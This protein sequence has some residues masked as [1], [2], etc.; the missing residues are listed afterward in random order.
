MTG[1]T[2]SIRGKTDI[3]GR[4]I[5]YRL[6][7]THETI[8]DAV[9]EMTVGDMDVSGRVRWK[10]FKSYD[11]W[12]TDSLNRRDDKLVLAIPKQPAAGKVIYDVSLTGPDGIERKLTDESVIIRFKGVVPPY[13]LWPHVVFMFIGMLVSNR[14]GLEAV[15]GG[16]GVFSYGL[17]TTILMV[18][19]G[20]IFGPIVQKYAFGAFWTGWP[21][22]HDLTDNK[23]FVAIIFWLI[24]L[25]RSRGGRSGRGWIITASL[26]TLLIYLIPHS[27]LGSEID[28]TKMEN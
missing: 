23:T 26:V 21:H 10:R 14:A 24:A 1:P 15:V 28:Y 4:E 22:G 19:G 7:T 5:S 27:V 6:L 8:S 16:K 12:T 13:V 18:L 25:W 3:S 17:I 11:E 20:L 2:Y 9:M